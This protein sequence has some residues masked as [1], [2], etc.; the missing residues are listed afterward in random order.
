MVAAKQLAAVPGWSHMLCT[1]VKSSPPDLL[2]MT[3]ISCF[4]AYLQDNRYDLPDLLLTLR[5][6]PLTV[7]CLL[8][9]WHSVPTGNHPV[10]ASLHVFSLLSASYTLLHRCCLSET[11]S[12]QA[13]LVD[14]D[15]VTML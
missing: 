14:H 2:C 9:T 15:T 6:E 11:C 3:I 12:Q 8:T 5:A 10:T 4:A 13:T 7:Q 1:R